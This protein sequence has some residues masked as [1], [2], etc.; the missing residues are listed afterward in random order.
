MDPEES[1]SPQKQ[2]L[3]QNERKYLLFEGAGSR[4]EGEIRKQIK[5]ER[6]PRL[7]NRIQHLV[8]DVALLNNR[9]FLTSEVWEDGWDQLQDLEY[10]PELR[11]PPVWLPN[12]E[13]SGFMRIGFV[14]GQFARTVSS[15]VGPDYDSAQL[16]W[17]F[18]LGAVGRPQGNYRR[19]HREMREIL[20]TIEKQFSRRK[21]TVEEQKVETESRHLEDDLSISTSVSTLSDGSAFREY[22]EK[23]AGERQRI[24]NSNEP[25]ESEFFQLLNEVIEAD[26]EKI[27]AASNLSHR[28]RRSI[29]EIQETSRR[30][31]PAED[32]FQTLYEADEATNSDRIA[33]D[34]GTHQKIVSYLMDTLAG[35]KDTELWADYPLVVEDPQRRG[36]KWEMTTFGK[37]VGACLFEEEG[38][39][40]VH[41]ALAETLTNGTVEEEYGEIIKEILEPDEN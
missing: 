9:D 37:L 27:I 3:Y 24:K 5:S 17:G 15:D 36:R 29:H 1:R 14:L 28:I 4:S 18:L 10:R 7:T 33:K 38:M 20:R 16:T 11:D 31:V 41:Q 8:D 34:C 39:E 12:T 35:E 22:Q 19:E 30:K 21:E 32:P 23:A 6:L 25:T 40:T 26:S 13:L 2:Y